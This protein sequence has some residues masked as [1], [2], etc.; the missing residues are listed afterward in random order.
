MGDRDFWVVTSFYNPVG[1]TR[2]TQNYRAFRLELGLPLLTI[3]LA[4]RG[5]F[6]LTP[7]DADVLLK[8]SGDDWIWQ[9]ERLLNIAIEALPTEARFV[10]W[11]DCDVMF[12][13]PSWAEE[14]KRVLNGRAA[15]V[16]PFEFAEHLPPEIVPTQFSPH[17][18]EGASPLFRELSFASS[19]ASNDYFR[20]GARANRVQAELG[21]SPVSRLPIAHGIAWAA[22]RDAIQALRLYDACVIGG[23]DFATSLA[24]IGRSHLLGIQRPMTERHCH[25]YLEWARPLAGNNH[26]SVG[27]VQGT[28]FHLW[29]GRYHRR[30]YKERHQ[31]L[32]DLEFDPYDHLRTAK[33]G[34]WSWAQHAA[35]L[36]SSVTAY[37]F[38]RKEDD[39]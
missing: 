6:C 30:R 29:H 36:R 25:H 11:V 10:A 37:F 15:F 20:S 12:G 7:P 38:S 8:V 14:A 21:L 33:N 34:T 28:L 24:F 9:K 17:V 22:R 23:G 31:L 32:K 39:V 35:A 1:Y 2:R 4:E 3:E 16:Q 13:N 27:F 5:R 26:T 19:L 18:P